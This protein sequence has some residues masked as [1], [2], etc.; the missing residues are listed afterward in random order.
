MRAEPDDS[1]HETP[2]DALEPADGAF[3]TFH[4]YTDEV[5]LPEDNAPPAEPADDIS[6]N[7]A[8]DH[9]LTDTGIEPDELYQQGLSEA[10]GVE[11]PERLEEPPQPLNPTEDE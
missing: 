5:H 1:T 10:A 11:P 3:H 9:P 2:D 6:A 7:L 8:P 4:P